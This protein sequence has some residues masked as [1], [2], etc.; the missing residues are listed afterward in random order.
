MTTSV[1]TSKNTLMSCGLQRVSRTILALA[2]VL[3]VTVS[4]SA[5][6]QRG[7][8][9]EI[10]VTATKRETALQNTPISMT[11]ITGADIEARSMRNLA[12]VADAVPNVQINF[13]SGFGPSKDAQITIR[14]IGGGTFFAYEDPRVGIY[15]D[16]VYLGRLTGGVLDL[17]NLE[18]VEVLRGPQGSLFGKNTVGGAVNVISKEPGDEFGGFVTVEA[19]DF[20]M[21][22]THFSVDIPVNDDMSVNVAGST[23]NRDG[24]VVS[25]VDGTDHQDDNT[26]TARVKMN[27]EPRQ[28]VDIN[29]SWDYTHQRNHG[30]GPV[31]D[32]VGIHDPT[33]S[34]GDAF[35]DFFY[36]AQEAR[37]GM[38]RTDFVS[39]DTTENFSNLE[40]FDDLD[41]WGTHLDIEWDVGPFSL[42]SI[43]AY[44]S[45]DQENLGDT[46]GSLMFI[47]QQQNITKQDQFSQ[48]LRLNTQ[49]FDD[50]LDVTAGF[51]H[52]NENVFFSIDF[53]GGNP[54]NGSL[55]ETLENVPGPLVAPP[56]APTSLCP[57][58]PMTPPGFPCFGGAGN[59]GNLAFAPG[60]QFLPIQNVFDLETTTYAG[61]AHFTF[62]LT[63]QINLVAG[64]RYSYEEKTHRQLIIAKPNVAGSNREELD[65][66]ELASFPLDATLAPGT[67]PIFGPA[68]PCFGNPDC[69]TGL[70][71]NTRNEDWSAWSPTFSIDYHPNEDLMLYARVSKGFKSGLFN[72]E[73]EPGCACNSGL[74]GADPVKQEIVWSYEGGFKSQWF[75]KRLTLNAAGFYSDFTDLQAIVFEPT[76]IN[77][78]TAVWRN[79]SDAKLWGFEAEFAAQPLDNL[80]VSGNVGWTDSS[81][82]GTNPFV[83]VPD[84]AVM[85]NVP[86]WAYDVSVEYVIPSEVGEFSL[87]ADYNWQDEQFEEITNNPLGVNDSFGLL[88]FRA[89]YEHPSGKFGAAAFVTNVTD[90]SYGEGIFFVDVFKIRYLVPG[91]PR[92]WGFSAT[93]R[94]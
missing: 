25:Q 45:M 33:A 68:N 74:L 13:S 1:V 39:H 85:P 17:V 21:I 87:R 67:H 37:F 8:L 23:H 38:N 9:E 55:F 93:Y 10:I 62:A 79:Q 5:L 92:M 35:F 54:F 26:K 15:M 61:F 2:T 46:D 77:P 65:R 51:Y 82:E 76:P 59:P 94:W 30:I 64:V 69:P 57:P 28:D 60:P 80:F 4:G 11:A 19:G 88:N 81:I 70:R 91:P 56:G 50:R 73:L 34:P 6:A 42:T 12:D 41:L 52:Y 48:E 72:G 90:E 7:I 24:F 47:T 40:S 18:R 27:W 71:D 53:D 29:W 31:L 78:A 14:G 22:N 58:G 89:S 49:L 43:T 84:G 75:N 16:G 83:T 44:R 36:R 20:D 63:E 86:E 32:F 3:C 66:L